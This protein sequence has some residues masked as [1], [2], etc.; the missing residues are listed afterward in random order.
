MPNPTKL[1]PGF[2]VDLGAIK[3]KI[4]TSQQPT[5]VPTQRGQFRTGAKGNGL[6][7]YKLQTTDTSQRKPSFR[8][9]KL[10]A[11]L[12]MVSS[13]HMNYL[14]SNNGGYYDCQCPA[15]KFDCRHK[16]IMQEIV[17]NKKQDTEYL[18]CFETRTFKKIEEIV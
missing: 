1:P 13:Y 2:K 18:F 6:T 7:F 17:A 9:T 8:I 5:A 4:P 11:D 16:Q 15:S 10:N 12:D 3:A 14:P